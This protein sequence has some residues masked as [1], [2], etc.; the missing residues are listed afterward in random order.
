[1]KSEETIKH[2]A[3]IT[4]SGSG[5]YGDRL[6]AFTLYNQ[7]W[8][9]DEVDG[10]LGR[11]L[12][13]KCNCLVDFG[14]GTGWC[15]PVLRKH[16]DRVVGIDISKDLLGV[17]RKLLET[18]DNSEG[19]D[20]VHYNGGRL[21]FADESID[22]IFEWDVMHHLETVGHTVSEFR[23]VLKRDGILIGVEPNVLNP[24]VTIYHARR[25]HE[26]GA[27]ATNRFGIK[28]KLL[29]G[30]ETAEVYSNNIAIS[31]N[32]PFYRKIIK[33]IDPLFTRWP[34]FRLFSL[35]YLFVA[36]KPKA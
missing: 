26:H 8:L 24:L 34:L 35:R 25:K 16:A 13:K 10:I 23:R 15:L 5:E 1:M 20:L 12:S 22:C 30:F 3:E 7:T 21:P 27:F 14:C 29:G 18:T 28:E 11:F 17:A 2:Y 31:Y 9:S 6:D 19:V 4:E 32:T 33:H 36:R